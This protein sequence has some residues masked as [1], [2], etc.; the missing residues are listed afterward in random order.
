MYAH[1]KKRDINKTS[2]EIAAIY[3]QA[4]LS[5]PVVP[6]RAFRLR[7]CVTQL[8]FTYATIEFGPNCQHVLTAHM[9]PTSCMSIFLWASINSSTPLHNRSHL[10]ENEIMNRWKTMCVLVVSNTAMRLDRD[11]FCAQ[12][13]SVVIEIRTQRTWRVTEARKL[14]ISIAQNRVQ[15]NCDWWLLLIR[16]VCEWLICD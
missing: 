4:Q 3:G 13:K 1:E 7:R 9:W 14:S 15:F 10:N 11:G 16:D 6:S 8:L 5:K 12:L 2:R